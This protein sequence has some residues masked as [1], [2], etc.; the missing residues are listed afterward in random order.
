MIFANRKDAGRKLAVVLREYKNNPNVLVLA[1]P[2]GGV[3][4]AAEVAKD[5]GVPLGIYLI[6]KLGY[7]GQKELAMGAIDILGEVA[8][9]PEIVASVSHEALEHEIAN[10]KK[11]LESRQKFYKTRVPNVKNKTVIVIDDGMATGASMRVAV[12]SLKKLGAQSVVVAVPVAPRETFESLKPTVNNIFTL[13]MPEYFRGVGA[14]YQDFNQVSDD[15]V[16]KIIESFSERQESRSA[17]V[18]PQMI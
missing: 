10:Q 9:N 18:E 17:K 5:L 11:R 16:V 12:S 7:P 2:R 3:P 15:E 6:R 4:V 8:L 1:L 14:W 13:D